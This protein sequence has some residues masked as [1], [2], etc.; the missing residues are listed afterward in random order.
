MTKQNKKMVDSSLKRPCQF[1][2]DDKP[3]NK[4]KSNHFPD[5]SQ[6]STNCYLF[7]IK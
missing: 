6:A 7:A 1:H 3:T 4:L 5:Q 2:P